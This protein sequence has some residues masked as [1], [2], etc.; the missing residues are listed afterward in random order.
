MDKIKQ[1]IY[2]VIGII[3][4]GLGII[5]VFVPLMPTTCFVL[6]AA[7]AFAKSSPA[8]YQRLVDNPHLGPRIQDWQK[9]RIISYSAKRIASLSIIA[10]IVLSMLLLK[11][12]VIS[13]IIL[14]LVML[15]LL[16]FINSRPS[17]PATS[18]KSTLKTIQNESDSPIIMT[19]TQIDHTLK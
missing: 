16:W 5:G 14:S 1:K 8:A 4:T 15:S 9:H 12:S 11:D 3:A 17:I 13:L 6:L 2:L 10:S 19:S 18:E 7:W